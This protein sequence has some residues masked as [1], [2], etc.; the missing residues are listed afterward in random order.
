VFTGRALAELAAAH[1]LKVELA[2]GS[3]YYPFGRRVSR[4]MARLDG[5]HA[6][7]LVQRYRVA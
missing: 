2:V 7:Y 5:R 4:L 1:G 6:A 3:G